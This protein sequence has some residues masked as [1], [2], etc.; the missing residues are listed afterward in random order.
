ML[1]LHLQEV[2]PTPV[3][4][5]F[6]FYTLS[7]R[8]FLSPIANFWQEI[9]DVSTPYGKSILPKLPAPATGIGQ[10]TTMR[11]SQI[12]TG[13]SR[14]APQ[15]NKI[16]QPPMKS[17]Q[18]PPLDQPMAA[19]VMFLNNSRLKQPIMQTRTKRQIRGTTEAPGKRALPGHARRRSA[20]I[21]RR[22]RDSDFPRAVRIGPK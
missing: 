7:I 21:A 5:N 4:R 9:Q 12:M 19:V 14:L 22:A 15:L 10:T 18:I 17:P 2:R 8:R 3:F 1:L 20:R 11:L 6:R 16:S 13:L